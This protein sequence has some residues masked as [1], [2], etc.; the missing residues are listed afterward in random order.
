VRGWERG[1]PV[2]QRGAPSPVDKV[3]NVSNARYPGSWTAFLPK[4][5][6]PG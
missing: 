5:V 2:A 4:G 6:I 3:V 1:R